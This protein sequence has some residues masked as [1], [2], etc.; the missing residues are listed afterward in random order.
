MYT[1][2]YIVD[3]S[4]HEVPKS[5]AQK[6]SASLAGINMYLPVAKASP[7]QIRVEYEDTSGMS[8]GTIV[9]NKST[10]N[11][12]RPLTSYDVDP[13]VPLSPLGVSLKWN[14]VDLKTHIVRGMPFGTMRYGKDTLPTI[15]SGNRPVSITRDSDGTADE[16]M[17]MMCGTFSGNATKQDG[18]TH[19]IPLTPDGKAKAYHVEREVVMHMGASDFT[20]VAFFSKPVMVECYSDV[21]KKVSVPGQRREGQFQ[22]NV[23]KVHDDDGKDEELVV[24][25]ALLNEC[26]S[27]KALNKEHCNKLKDLD[28][29]TISSKEKSKA[30]LEALRKG[31]MMYPKSPLV[32][33]QFPEEGGSESD[34][35]SEGD[36]VTNVVF[37]WDPISVGLEAVEDSALRASAATVND[38]FI[39]FAMPH[40]LQL[41]ASED[42]A[43]IGDSLCINTFHGRTCLVRGS[44][45]NL[46]ISHGSPQSFLA[47]R[48]PL[49]KAIPSLAKALQKD[50]TF[51]FSP[52]MLRGAPDTYYTAKILAKVGRIIEING[53]LQS[54]HADENLSYVD[55]DDDAVAE[56]ASTAFKVTV[57]SDE[58]LK[59]L[60]D[61]LQ[62]AVEIWL[63]PGGKEK[64]GAEAEFLYDATWGGFVNCGCDFRFEKGHEDSGKCNNTFPVCPALES[65]Q[66]NFGNAW[67]NGTSPSFHLSM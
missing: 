36:R 20:W 27:G 34:Q 63:K 29:D 35:N 37:D 39:M 62:Q 24:Q 40:H 66:V 59:P 61:D 43:D 48:P 14:H 22:L 4:P 49:A 23:V 38:E 44:V 8:L 9:P 42:S 19:I 55:A 54:L 2:P 25:L 56:A 33:T 57:P 45:W 50:I 51:K 7:T 64:G 46:P 41:L 58:E 30:Y 53:E 13:E 18:S 47:D 67:Y 10:G 21:L 12:N 65:D 17:K 52:A 15:L 5:P 6:Q 28:F 11:D 32:E 31:S 1:I 3:V 16:D 60:L 26:T